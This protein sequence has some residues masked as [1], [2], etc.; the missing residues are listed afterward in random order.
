M[1][2]LFSVCFVGVIVSPVILII[3]VV[4][5]FQCFSFSSSVSLGMHSVCA[6]S[7]SSLWLMGSSY[8]GYLL[9]CLILE[10]SVLLLEYI[11]RWQ[12]HKRWKT[13]WFLPSGT[14]VEVKAPNSQQRHVKEASPLSGLSVLS[15]PEELGRLSS[16]TNL[17]CGFLGIRG[18][19][20]NHAALLSAVP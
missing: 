18:T 10:A 7:S 4:V 11:Q 14:V 20:R 13:R 12:D 2:V 1:F 15:P 19:R 9:L 3:A 6:N 8:V 5:S 16:H 17:F